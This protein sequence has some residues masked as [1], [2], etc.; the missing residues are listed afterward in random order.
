MNNGITLSG[1]TELARTY[2]S[3]NNTT[4]FGMVPNN[5]FSRHN[6]M[7]KESFSLFNKKLD[8]STSLNYIHQKTTNR[9][10]I[11]RVLSPLHALYRMPSNV[12]MRYFRNHYQHTGTTADQWCMIQREVIPNWQDNLS[13]HGIGTINILTIPTG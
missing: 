11:G 1:G 2:F 6:F 13:K 7:F 5:K 10:V 12:D 8:I 3:Y 9:P 4:Q